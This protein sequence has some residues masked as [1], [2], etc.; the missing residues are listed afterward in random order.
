MV[1]GP[2]EVDYACLGGREKNKHADKRG[3]R[4]KRRSWA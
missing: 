1:S 3:K 4:G 2:I